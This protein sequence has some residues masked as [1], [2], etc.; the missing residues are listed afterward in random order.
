MQSIVIAGYARSPFHFA[1]KGGLI[2]LRPDDLAAQVVKGLV[3]RLDIDPRQIE[4][5][6][7]GCAY[8][9][10]EQGMNLA[11]ITGFLAGLPETVAGATVNRFCGSSMSAIHF[12][13]GQI[14][15]GA[16]EAFICGG[17]ESMTRVPMGGFNISPNPKLVDGY[18]QAYMAMGHT[19]EVVAGRYDISRVDQEAMAVESHRKATQAREQGRLQDELIA[20]ETPDGLVN[21]DGCI[22]PATTPEA[23]AQL[24][25]AF[26]GSVTAGTA[27]PL[28]DGAAAVFVCTE[29]FAKRWSLDVMARIK[30]V[31][32]VGCPPEIMGM[33]PLYATRKLLQRTGLV[34]GDIDLFEINEAFAS[35][36]LACIRELDLDPAKVNLDGGAMAIGHPLGA[37]GARITGKAASLLKRTGG[38]YAVATQCIG[39]GQGVATLLERV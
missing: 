16:G 9:E 15:L 26:G 4:D 39:G 5:L 2:N 22:R 6:I 37:T 33:G 23:L 17:V 24:K 10:A 27:S 25:P 21:E 11:R 18:P 34:I 29:D 28:T 19:A 32:V 1:K 13:A 31:A 30:A 36:A 35:Q 3:D 20:I 12:A 8:P 38:R 14:M 7:L